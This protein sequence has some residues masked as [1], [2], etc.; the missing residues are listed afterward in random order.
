MCQV[1][2]MQERGNFQQ[3]RD[4]L[5]EVASLARARL[6]TCC[7]LFPFVSFIGIKDGC[8]KLSI[9]E[10]ACGIGFYLNWQILVGK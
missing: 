1:L 5:G 6:E 7:L 9:L 8:E 3:R 10:R 4:P 2:T